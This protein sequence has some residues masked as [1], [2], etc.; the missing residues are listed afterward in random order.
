MPEQRRQLAIGQRPIDNHH[1][2]VRPGATDELDLAVVLITA[3]AFGVTRESQRGVASGCPWFASFSSA[4]GFGRRRDIRLI[5][6]G[7]A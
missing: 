1:L 2:V 4:Q 6:G 3:T 5:F 7:L